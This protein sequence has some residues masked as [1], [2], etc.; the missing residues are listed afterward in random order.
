VLRRS[1]I[2]LADVNLDLTTLPVDVGALHAL[3]RD[4]AAQMTG[5]RAELARTK[6]EIDKLLIATTKLNN[7][8]PFAWLS[9]VLQSMTDGHP[10]NRLD[11]LLPWNWQPI[12]VNP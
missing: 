12:N 9:D 11:E 4:L 5:E 10:A 6:A 1:G 2:R 3:V 7:V 8:D